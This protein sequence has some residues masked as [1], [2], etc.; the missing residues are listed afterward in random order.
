MTPAL[1][2][3]WIAG[4]PPFDGLTLSL[5]SDDLVPLPALRRA[6]QFVVGELEKMYPHHALH[7][8]A[9]WHEHDGCLSEPRASSW[10]ELHAWLA[11]DESLRAAGQGDTYVRTA[12]MPESGEFYLRFYVP[13]EYD[14]DYPE[15][16]GSFDLAC[17]EEVARVLAAETALG[18]TNEP[19]QEFFDRSYGG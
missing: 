7:T 11:S 1:H 17:P 19:A 12:V 15:P 14:N 9:D 5:G 6:L 13:D 8:A 10:E 16:R 18:L 3:R 2:Q 4:H